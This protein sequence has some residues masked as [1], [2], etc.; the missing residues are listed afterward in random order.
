VRHPGK[1][2]KGE[3]RGPTGWMRAVV[4]LWASGLKKRGRKDAVGPDPKW[5]TE[6]KLRLGFREI[7]SGS[8]EW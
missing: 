4:T 1:N 6:K 7:G 5:G 8:P 3:S 2:E